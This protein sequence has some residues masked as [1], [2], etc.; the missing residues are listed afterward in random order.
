MHK[1]NS[2]SGIWASETQNTGQHIMEVVGP[3]PR[4]GNKF[5]DTICILSPLLDSIQLRADYCRNIPVVYVLKIVLGL[6]QTECSR[7]LANKN[8]TLFEG[9]I[10]I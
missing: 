2:Q 6:R 8:G 7:K 10:F 3:T 4:I 9:K 5:N 1:G